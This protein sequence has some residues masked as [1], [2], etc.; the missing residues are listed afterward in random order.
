MLKGKKQ[1]FLRQNSK[2]RRPHIMKTE[3]IYN[4]IK[5]TWSK[6]TEHKFLWTSVAF[7]VLILFFDQNS[8]IINMAP[9]RKS[10]SALKK[11]QQYYIDKIHNDSLMLYEL[12][13]ND[14]NLE[15]FAREHYYMK[16]DDEDIFI[17]VEKE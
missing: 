7:L 9:V 15:K 13:T 6:I 8:L 11:E 17:I 4:T 10:I 1:L 12:E 2:N 5:T 3:K 16:A 14:N